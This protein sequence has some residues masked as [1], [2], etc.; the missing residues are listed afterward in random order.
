MATRPGLAEGIS[1]LGIF[2]PNLR[3]S[4]RLECVSPQELWV[5]CL[6]VHQSLAPFH[7]ISTSWPKVAAAA[8]AIDAM[9]QLAEH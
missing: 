4:N 8:L 1:F 5:W 7:A 6:Y 9:F 2:T 3:E